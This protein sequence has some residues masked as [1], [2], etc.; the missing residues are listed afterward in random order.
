MTSESV[1]I[2]AVSSRGSADRAGDQR[3]T[4]RAFSITDFCHLYGI[5][6]TTAYAEI[7][8]GRL[9]AVKVG[10]RTLIPS[11]AAEGWL[12]LLPEISARLRKRG[13]QQ[14]NTTERPTS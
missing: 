10:H 9:R 1:F 14:L 8:A 12:A 4:A 6:R 13:D 11:D 5:G 7:A 2:A 3:L